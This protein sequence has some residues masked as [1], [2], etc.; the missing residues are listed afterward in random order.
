MS[1]NRENAA[2][3]D[4][5]RCVFYRVFVEVVINAAGKA[6]M[7][8]EWEGARQT[9]PDKQGEGADRERNCQDIMIILL[10]QPSNMHNTPSLLWTHFELLM[11]C[12]FKKTCV[13]ILKLIKSIFFYDKL[14]GYM[15]SERLS[16][17]MYFWKNRTRLPEGSLSPTASKLQVLTKLR[18]NL[19][20]I[21][22]SP[23][24]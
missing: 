20:Q 11:Y 7:G 9:K 24:E 22:R 19:K 15:S 10:Y 6:V 17:I 21:I 13:D 8:A 14:N 5:G 1:L 18:Q 12:V 3:L 4:Q 2:I 23:D 16:W